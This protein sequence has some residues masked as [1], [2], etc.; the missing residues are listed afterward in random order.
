MKDIYEITMQQFNFSSGLY[1]LITEL[2]PKDIPLG[3][4]NIE[5]M[6]LTA[7]VYPQSWAY[8]CLVNKN[9]F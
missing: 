7:T 9:W 2:M 6:T 1:N 3:M 4:Y 5:L 8:N